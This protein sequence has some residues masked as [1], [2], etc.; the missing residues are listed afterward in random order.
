VHRVDTEDDSGKH[1]T[2]QQFREL[3]HLILAARKS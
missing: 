2:G 3:L 1:I